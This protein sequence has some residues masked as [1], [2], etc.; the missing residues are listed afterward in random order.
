MPLYV[1]LVYVTVGCDV[2]ASNILF[3]CICHI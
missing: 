3:A 1:G 2:L